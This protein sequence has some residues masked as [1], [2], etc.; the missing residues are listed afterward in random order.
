MEKLAVLGIVTYTFLM[1]P[2]WLEAFVI[3]P[4]VYWDKGK[5]DKPQST[6]I[7]AG[8]I[9]LVGVMV[10]V[11]FNYGYWYYAM[12]VATTFHIGA[13][14][15]LVNIKLNREP[16]YLGFGDYDKVIKKIP[17]VYRLIISGILFAGSIVLFE[18]TKF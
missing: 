6:Y 18:L 5:D 2:T 15:Y 4:L 13:F 8:M 17:L 9:I 3:D 14:A 7:R 16:E 11:V 12:V 1:L 10:D